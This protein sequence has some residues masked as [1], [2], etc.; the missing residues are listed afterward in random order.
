MYTHFA[1]LKKPLNPLSKWKI[2]KPVC[3]TNPGFSSL[4]STAA[5]W[6]KYLFKNTVS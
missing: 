3:Q 6:P 4:Q 5:L 2:R 1:L